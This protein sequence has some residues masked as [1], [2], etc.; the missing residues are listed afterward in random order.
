MSKAAAKSNTSTPPDKR[1]VLY[2]PV[3]GL[4]E[5]PE[6]NEAF[7]RGCALT[8]EFFYRDG[9]F[10]YVDEDREAGVVLRVL[11]PG[12][13]VAKIATV[14]QLRKKFYDP[15][16]GAILEK[17]VN[18]TLPEAVL[19][20]ADEGEMRKASRWLRLLSASPIIVD[21]E[22]EPAVLGR[23]YHEAV[24]GVYVMGELKIP[25]MTL[26]QART[27]LLDLFVDYDFVSPGDLSR[28]VAQTL[29]PAL[30]LGNLLE[31][32]F[33]FDISLADQSQAG[34]T[35]RMRIIATVY[36]E[37]AYVITKKAGGVGSFDESVSAA[38][39]SA[40]LFVLVDNARGDVDSQI[41]ESILRGFGSVEIRV[42]YRG[43]LEVSTR[44][45]LLQL[46]SNAANFTK[47]LAARS[48]IISN[49]KRPPDY[50]ARSS[51]GWGDEVLVNLSRQRAEY[52]GAV[53]VVVSEWIRRGKKRTDEARHAFRDWVQALDYIVQ[54]IL[55]LSPLMEGQAT[56]RKI[57]SDP[58]Y[59][60]LREVALKVEETR[61]LGE[62]FQAGDIGDLCDEE[63]ITIPGLRELKAGILTRREERNKQIG[64]NLRKVFEEVPPVKHPS[65]GVEGLRCLE[66][67][68][69]VVE[70]WEERV[71]G[72]TKP[73]RKY[74]F[75]KPK[76]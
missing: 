64:V 44:R 54:E 6:C 26:D 21:R 66:L 2:L 57:I 35:H 20:L 33:P 47:D 24:G 14:F 76:P 10:S 8:K 13:L 55:G 48:L 12:E 45:C 1:P 61:R 63:G 69:Y 25:E 65:S 62:T 38:L 70:R 49:R 34:K 68:T 43:G 23:G 37:K 18:L 5:P 32:D 27:L 9:A 50:A 59:G 39:L 41:L 30:K 31:T 73:K 29:S 58:V 42:P 56:V 46:T 22:G 60:W 40:K 17:P 15:K 72:E 16:T 51:L 36:G 4:T 52:L 53:H 3:H 28:A 74:R 11:K 7:Y 71:P 19:L 67:E 75:L